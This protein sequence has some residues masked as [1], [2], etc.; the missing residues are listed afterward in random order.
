M[1]LFRQ[2]QVEHK[3]VVVRVEVFYPS[4]A[5]ELVRTVLPC[6]YACNILNQFG[7]LSLLARI[8]D[9]LIIRW[10]SWRL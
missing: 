10:L 3:A 5:I 2:R 7:F 1:E 6:C 9:W 4:E 8:F